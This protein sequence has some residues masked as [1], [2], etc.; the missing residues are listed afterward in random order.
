MVYCTAAVACS[1]PHT[2]KQTAAG[3]AAASNRQGKRGLGG[4]YRMERTKPLVL[5]VGAYD[6]VVSS[7]YCG[8]GK[9]SMVVPEAYEVPLV[10][11]LMPVLVEKSEIIRWR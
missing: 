2:S 9:A 8:V 4:V 6:W 5:S 11:V 10:T 7:V 1:R 3:P